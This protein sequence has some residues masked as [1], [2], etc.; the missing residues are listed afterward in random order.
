MN[1]PRVALLSMALC[2]LLDRYASALELKALE[3]EELVTILTKMDVIASQDLE[4][5]A[6]LPEAIRVIGVV[7]DGECDGSPESCPLESIYLAIS[8]TGEDPQRAVY[9]LPDAHGWKFGSWLHLPKGDEQS[10]YF[11]FTMERKD[12][13]PDQSSGWWA[14]HV[15]KIRANIYRADL[16][17][18]E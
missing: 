9:K 4:T 18:M 10:E 15:V 5:Q 11:T 8:T 7:H 16:E 14:M 2:L 1:W 12:V 3:N 6:D 13:A 17:I